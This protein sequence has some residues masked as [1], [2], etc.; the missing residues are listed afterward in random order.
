MQDFARFWIAFENHPKV[1]RHSARHFRF[2][3]ANCWNIS[4]IFWNCWNL[5]ISLIKGNPVHLVLE[6]RSFCHFASACEHSCAKWTRL[7]DVDI[8]RSTYDEI[9]TSENHIKI[10]SEK[11]CFFCFN[12]VFTMEKCMLGRRDTSYGPPFSCRID[13]AWLELE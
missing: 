6:T 13:C 12:F 8:W 11:T 5:P 1:F 2:L 7:A 3:C 4:E 10:V 9:W